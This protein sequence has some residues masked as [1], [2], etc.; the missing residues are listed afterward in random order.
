MSANNS[1]ILNVSGMTCMKC[2]AKV[3]KALSEVSGVE[4]VKVDLE[5]KK[6]KV[7]FTDPVEKDELVN[8]IVNAGYQA[9]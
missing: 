9:D 6:A 4:K 2:A 7:K 8:A 3:E 1:I 5:A